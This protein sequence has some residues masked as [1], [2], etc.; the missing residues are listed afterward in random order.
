MVLNYP[1]ILVLISRNLGTFMQMFSSV[2]CLLLHRCAIILCKYAQPQ[3]TNGH[4]SIGITMSFSSTAVDSS[5]RNSGAEDTVYGEPLRF[6]IC[7]VDGDMAF[8]V[9]RYA[10]LHIDEIDVLLSKTIVKIA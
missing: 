8:N 2:S 4:V 5:C 3:S 1:N 7:T 9:I 6:C 10:Y